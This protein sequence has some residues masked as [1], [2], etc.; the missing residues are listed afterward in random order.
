MDALGFMPSLS[1][2]S[3]GLIRSPASGLTINEPGDRYEQEADRVADQVMR[4]PASESVQA[5]RATSG[6]QLQRACAQCEEEEK[7][8][9][10]KETGAGPA[11]APP[12]VHEVLGSPGQPL[13]ADAR[14]FM[15]PRFG[16]DFGSVRVHSDA[17]AANSARAVNASAYTVGNHMVAG[18]AGFDFSSPNGRRLLAHELTHVVQQSGSN[19]PRTL[20]R[21]P[22]EPEQKEKKP[23]PKPKGPKCDTGCSQRWG[24]DTTCSKWGYM[25]SMREKMTGKKWDAFPCCNSWPLSLETYARNQLG[26]E[27]VASCTAR[28]EREVATVSFGDKEVQVLCSDTIPNDM[29]GET[30]DAK[31]CT[32]S[33]S[34]EVLEMSPKAM[35]DL[36]GQLTNALHVKVCYSGQKLD[37]CLHNGPGA[38]SFPKIE[39]CL[40]RGCSP[41]EDAPSHKDS[42]WPRA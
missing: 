42:G 26:I 37:M 15:E 10:R 34:N 2:S 9:H 20:A 19:A 12:I 25:E 6:S 28:H 8:I 3:P 35:Q 17:K 30:A 22:A 36:S 14:A 33:I 7:G 11:A 31:D 39:Q 21:A 13:D 23:A 18:P 29:F 4:M 41:V 40:T 38:R 27:G 32:G 16:H 1:H 5:S 24:Q